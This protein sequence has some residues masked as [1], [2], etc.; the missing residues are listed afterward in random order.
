MLVNIIKVATVHSTLHF[1]AQLCSQ[2][3]AQIT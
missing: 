2:G 1:Q 3:C